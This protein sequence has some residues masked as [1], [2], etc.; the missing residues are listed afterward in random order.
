M[1]LIET[2]EQNLIINDDSSF[3][4]IKA[5][6][7]T[8]KTTTLKRFS[9]ARPNNKILYMAYN[10]ETA[11]QARMTF[12]S[13]VT[14]KTAHSIA[15]SKIGY[16][17]A[18]KLN[19]FH[20]LPFKAETIRKFFGFKRN[21]KS[22]QLSRDIFEIVNN[23][24]FSSYRDIKDAIPFKKLTESREII[25]VYLEL[26]WEEMI[27][28]ENNF[29]ITPD[30][31]LKL[32][33]LSNPKL[34]YDYILFDEVQDANPLILDLVLS[35]RKFSTK[36]IFVGDSHQSI[37][38][39]RGAKN[40]FD[41]IKSDKELYLTKSFRFGSNIAFAAN[42]ILSVLKKETKELEGFSE[43]YDC[44]GEVDQ[45]KP[46]ALISRTNANLFLSAIAAYEKG[47][48]ISFVGGFSSYHFEKI[49]DV[50]KLF[51]GENN[52]IKDNYIRSFNSFNDYV[53]TATYSNDKEMI[54]CIRLIE[55]YAGKL[56]DL[57]K[58]IK[59]SVVDI[60]MANIILSTVH[61]S[62]GLEFK[63]VILA[64]DF[65][66]FVNNQEI[67]YKLLKEDEINILYVAATR[68]T[69]VLKTN[70]TLK[71]IIDYYNTNKINNIE[72][73]SESDNIINEQSQ[74]IN[75][76]KNKF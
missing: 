35:Q 65:P 21:Q 30:V 52:K 3:L 67:N 46:F 4:S 33:S 69:N 56:R 47:L 24:C 61:K 6:A 16:K 2:N 75:K 8:G 37:Y 7:G 42:A 54:Y 20:T 64:N 49:L 55:K 71:N 12:P 51:F 72:N 15:Y 45:S 25:S 39:F 60:N 13:N 9:L 19:K 18:K 31:Y 43:I 68:A 23:F 11:K 1:S 58:G 27:N 32:Y 17:Y 22:M 14:S 44:V 41:L 62:K 36:L 76:I 38:L 66:L 40:S 34:D 59:D 74:I 48:N 63:Q 29:P 10:K 57:I 26:L 50:E 73:P 70:K 5:F 53:S 28:V